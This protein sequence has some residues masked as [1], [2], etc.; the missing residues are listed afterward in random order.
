MG[1]F[2]VAFDF[3]MKILAYKKGAS[4]LVCFVSS[5]SITA[6]LNQYYDLFVKD[7]DLKVLFMPIF[8]EVIMFCIFFMLCLFD[9]RYGSKVAMKFRNEEFDWDKVWDTAAKMFGIVFITAMLM[10]FSMIF[11][12]LDSRA[13]WWASFTPLCFL[14]LLANGF[15]FGSLG[16][17]IEALRGDKPDIFKFF[18]NVLNVL[19][20]KA[21][22]KIDNS[23]NVLDDEKDSNNNPDS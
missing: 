6:L 21:L 9:L 4:A 23:F 14:W 22:D 16:R 11:E 17:H 20:R 2:Q 7:T 10:I 8:V 12:S 5:I 18:D 3:L 13:L 1:F 15:E 19:Q